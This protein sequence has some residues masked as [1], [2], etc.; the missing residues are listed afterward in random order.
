MSAK[1]S[2]KTPH[3]KPVDAANSL[4]S[5][6]KR[7]WLDEPVFAL[8]DGVSYS[9]RAMAILMEAPCTHAPRKLQNICKQYHITTL[10][11]LE[12]IGSDGLLRC[13]G[14]GEDTAWM[15]AM[16]LADHGRDVDAWL[17]RKYRT[18]TH[19]DVLRLVHSRTRKQKH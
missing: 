8:N 6:R 17:R 2:G 10:D 3:R 18:G 16:I 14:I 1:T 4:L 7:A 5:K 12:R 9:R 15:A 11:Q 19:R 13:V